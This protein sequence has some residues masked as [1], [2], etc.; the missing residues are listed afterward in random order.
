M[1]ATNRTIAKNRWRSTRPLP[2]ITSNYFPAKEILPGLWIGSEGDARSAAFFRK[3]DIKLVINATRNVPFADRGADVRGYRVPVN[4]DPAD[5]EIMAR[6]LPIVV[7]VIDEALRYG[8][9]VLVHC[10]AGMQR[11]AAVVAAYVMYKMGMSADEALEF[12]N[13]RKNETFW[14]V[15]TFEP[16]L[17]AFEKQIKTL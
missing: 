13:Y 7:M 16:A 2:E 11:S 8:G 12:V 5:N 10:R 1:T 15:A 4:D 14:P 6:H 3:H 17:R 9:G